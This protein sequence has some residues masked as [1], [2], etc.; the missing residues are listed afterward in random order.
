MRGSPFPVM[1]PQFEE[2]AKRITD[3]VANRITD[4]VA[5]RITDDVAN[6][7]TDDVARRITDDVAPRITADVTNRVT[8]NVE[9]I[10]YEA[11]EELRH[12]AR[13]NVEEVK[14]Q[15]KAVA[16]NDGGVLDDIHRQLQD[17]NAKV[18]VKFRDH[19][20]VL[21]NHHSRITKLEKR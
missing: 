17:L 6:R 15:A 12:Q 3:D 14:A 18:D 21:A 7:I 11:K 4:D 20:V 5:R 2:L 9:R 10:V 19:D 8:A 16:E 1:E 13:V